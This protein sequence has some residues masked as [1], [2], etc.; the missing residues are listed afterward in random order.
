MHVACLSIRRNF[1][2]RGCLTKCAKKGDSDIIYWRCYSFNSYITQNDAGGSWMMSADAFG[3]RRSL[4][5]THITGRNYE[6]V[7]I[8]GSQFEIRTYYLPNTNPERYQN[9]GLRGKRERHECCGS[10]NSVQRTWT[11]LLCS[12][13]DNLITLMLFHYASYEGSSGNIGL[14]LVLQG[15]DVVTSSAWISLS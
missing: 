3:R 15:C 5:V 1:H 2:A 9:T 12:R 6:N 4:S 13:E 7:T 14:Y 11:D 10:W 8:N